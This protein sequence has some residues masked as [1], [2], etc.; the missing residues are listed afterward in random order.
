[1]NISA[2]KKYPDVIDVFFENE[3]LC[4]KL[5]DGRIIQAPLAWFPR[6]ANASI[7]ERNHWRL[8]ADGY[9][10]HW[11]DIDEHISADGLMGTTVRLAKP[12][13]EKEIS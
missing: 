12:H 8:I 13:L 11:P 10:V 7:A 2:N 6:L 9:G 1:M 5:K 3:M 4:L